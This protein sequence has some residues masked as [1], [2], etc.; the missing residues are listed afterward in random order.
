MGGSFSL[1]G[2]PGDIGKFPEELEGSMH[3]LRM[4]ARLFRLGRILC[5][6][7]RRI[8]QRIAILV[9]GQFLSSMVPLL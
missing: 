7:P 1:G 4:A 9:S 2:G 8:L 5:T 6:P 3:G